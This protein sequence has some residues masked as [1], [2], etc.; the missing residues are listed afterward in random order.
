[1]S[2]TTCFSYFHSNTGSNL[3][4]KHSF[5][6]YSFWV[7]CRLE[8]FIGLSSLFLTW[9]FLFCKMSLSWCPSPFRLLWQTTVDGVASKQQ[10]FLFHSSESWKS[11]IKL[12]VESVSGED[13]VS[14]SHRWPPSCRVLS[15]AEGRERDSKLSLASLFVRGHP[16]DLIHPNYL[17]KSPSP[18]AILLGI[19]AVMCEF[20]GGGNLVQSN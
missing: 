3:V 9:A 14:D 6:F 16:Q 1:M 19:R 4:I 8:R 15:W 17:P 18:N 11:K 7:S 20:V 5:N 13:S 10:K 2:H 12:R